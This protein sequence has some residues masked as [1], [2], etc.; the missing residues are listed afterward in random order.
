MSLAIQ[1]KII[2]MQ[3]ANRGKDKAST[4][5]RN[6]GRAVDHH[7]ILLFRPWFLSLPTT[8]ARQATPRSLAWP[9]PRTRSA[10]GLEPWTPVPEIPAD[11]C[12]LIRLVSGR[13]CGLVVSSC[14]R[15][16][17]FESRYRW[18]TFFLRTCWSKT[19][20]VLAHSAKVKM[21]QKIASA[22]QYRKLKYA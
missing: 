11:H 19:C 15:G 13:G 22:R 9:S 6:K 4:E 17:E 18:Q 10:P 5:I 3:K 8:P 2:L 16:L 14:L 7:L 21:E 12:Y 20:S 1:S